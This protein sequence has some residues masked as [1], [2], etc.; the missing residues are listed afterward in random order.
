MSHSIIKIMEKLIFQKLRESGKSGVFWGL[1]LGMLSY[2]LL[3]GCYPELQTVPVRK[4]MTWDQGE[5][6]KDSPEIM[7]LWSKQ[8]EK[9]YTFPVGQ[10]FPPPLVSRWFAIYF[11]AMHDALNSADPRYATYAS[12]IQDNKADPNAALIQAVYETLIT[13]N[14]PQ[15]PSI[16]SLYTATMG[17]I[18]DGEKK[19]RGIV[20]GKAVAQ[21]LLTK[22]AAD[23]PYLQLIGY[24][25]TPP[26]GTQPGE[27]RYLPPLNY[28]LSGYHL[29]QPWVMSSGDQFRPGPPYSI[30]SPEY[31]QDFN[32]VKDL[33]ASN[34][35]LVTQDQ[36]ALGIFWAEN[37]NR[38]WNKIAREVLSNN[39][40]YYNVWEVARLFALM[41][42]AIADSYI[43]VFDSK[44]YYNYWRPISAIRMGDTDGN[45]NTLGD[46]SWTPAM[47]TPAIG[48]YPSA[49]AIAGSAAGGV[50]INFFRKSDMPF[51]MDSGY[52]PTT[53]NFN[54]IQEAV[55]ENSLSRIYIGYHFR[56]AVDVGEEKGYEIGNFV[57]GNA[58]KS[59]K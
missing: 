48:E 20:L 59:V 41:H 18:K 13:M 34:S 1:F 26:N 35:T 50:L 40:K 19:E 2:G 55:R 43:S 31:A 12:T 21:E 23:N 25:P 10:G 42:M 51:V 16:D 24:N 14:A 54:S 30:N 15:K 52:W 49:H 17:K 8:I 46:D 9:A 7:L 6:L 38:G 27:Y 4:N 53:R 5:N 36:R 11:V 33:G 29:Q 28:A 56:K 57:F 47:V 37:S 3:T 44:V 22:R 58:L 32:E 45:D 39:K